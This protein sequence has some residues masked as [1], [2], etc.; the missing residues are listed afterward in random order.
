MNGIGW[1]SGWGTDYRAPH[2]LSVLLR[3]TECVQ[4][5]KDLVDAVVAVP[6]ALRIGST[7]AGDL[8]FWRANL[9]QFSVFKCF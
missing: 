8:S 2:K 5:K 4:G 1:S 9:K 6:A 7:V 3:S